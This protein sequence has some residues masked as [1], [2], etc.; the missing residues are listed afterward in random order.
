[1]QRMDSERLL[2]AA[3]GD[4]HSAL[5][6]QRGFTLLAGESIVFTTSAQNINPVQ[7]HFSP[8]CTLCCTALD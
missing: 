7:V 6:Q 4:M 2:I 8:P 5:A 1:M 3:G